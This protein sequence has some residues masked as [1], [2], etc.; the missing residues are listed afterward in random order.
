[1]RRTQDLCAARPQPQGVEIGPQGVEIRPARLDDE[2][3]VRLFVLGLSPSTRVQRF[4]AGLTRP[5][6]S[7][8]RTMVARDDRRDALLAVV[9]DTVIG[10]AMS[11]LD[12]GEAEIAVVVDDDWQGLGVG[13]RLVRTL[14][15]RAA[16]RGATRVGM[17]VMGENR[18][19]LS[20]IRRAWPAATTMVESGSVTVKSPL[21]FAEQGSVG[22]PLT[23]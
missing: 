10:H 19:V 4:F 16:G 7:L 15:E 13:S 12:D 14:L 23:L 17:D 9:G 3:R 18:K 11:F 1:M 8:V 20:M 22:P 6:A 21:I 5:S 2:G